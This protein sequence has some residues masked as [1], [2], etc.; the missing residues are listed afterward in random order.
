MIA[1]LSPEQLRGQPRA[2]M[3]AGGGDLA[4]FRDRAAAATQ[5]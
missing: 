5:N 1:A 4:H 2:A 3:I